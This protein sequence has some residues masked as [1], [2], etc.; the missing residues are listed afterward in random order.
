MAICTRAAGR[1]ACR[2]VGDRRTRFLHPL[3]RGGK[4]GVVQV[5]GLASRIQLAA[6]GVWLLLLPGCASLL[7]PSLAARSGSNWFKAAPTLPDVSVAI[8]TTV[9]P[10]KAPGFI[11]LARAERVE[12]AALYGVRAYSPLWIDVAGRPNRAAQ[13]AL[14]LL[15]GAGDEGL[16][17]ADYGMPELN[18]LAMQLAR[19]PD[20]ASRAS[21]DVALSAS[22]L[23]FI[24]H[25]NMGRVNPSTVG[26]ELIG[27]AER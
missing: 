20:P 9:N 4:G 24:R 6:L 13:D 21:F 10:V 14:M 16:D 1:H 5:P 25:L 2:C 19:L 18:R 27:S 8:R 12:L 26:F 3:T 17:P 15:D 22:M 23:R 11:R 7:S